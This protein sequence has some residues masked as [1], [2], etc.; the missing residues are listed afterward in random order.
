MH[1]S[2]HAV[3]IEIDAFDAFWTYTRRFCAVKRLDRTE[4]AVPIHA[5]WRT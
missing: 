5:D 4:T 3:W 1:V 2:F